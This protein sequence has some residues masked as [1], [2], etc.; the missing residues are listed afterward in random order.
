MSFSRIC[1][2]QSIDD[3]VI[4]SYFVYEFDGSNRF[5]TRPKRLIFTGHSN[6]TIQMWDLT[7]AFDL[8]AKNEKGIIF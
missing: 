6:G 2:I 4:S 3:S 5:G 7:T 1:V 8:F